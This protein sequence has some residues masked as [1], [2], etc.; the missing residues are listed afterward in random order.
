[1]TGIDLGRPAL[2][3]V[4]PCRPCAPTRSPVALYEEWTSGPATRAIGI[5]GDLDPAPAVD[6]RSWS[7]EVAPC[8]GF[9]P[10]LSQAGRRVTRPGEANPNRL[11][12]WRV[13]PPL[14]M[15]PGPVYTPQEWPIYSRSPM[16]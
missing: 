8:Q 4:R 12:V 5:Q 15:A 7:P 14:T 11:E 1:M 6:R 13:S 10:E 9:P 16:R 2:A 3:G